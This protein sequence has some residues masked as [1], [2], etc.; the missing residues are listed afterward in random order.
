MQQADHQIKPGQGALT[1]GVHL[2]REQSYGAAFG[3]FELG[4][5]G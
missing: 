5:V 1:T 3:E 4:T 2:I